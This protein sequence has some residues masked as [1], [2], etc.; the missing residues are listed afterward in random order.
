MEFQGKKMKKPLALNVMSSGKHKGFGAGSIDLNNVSPVIIDEGRAYIDLGAMHAKSKVERGIKFLP[1][2]E[3][4]PN[5]RQCWIVWV[6]V[7]RLPIGS[8]YGGLAAC[9]MLIDT[10]IKRGWKVLADHVNRMDYAMKRHVLI[11]ELNVE[12]K[13]A[14]RELLMTHNLEWWERTSEEMK[15]KLV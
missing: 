9:E 6:A 7:D 3:D 14:L 8:C 4:V 13:S 2:K 1:N 5:G 12:D 10:E 11:D 15:A